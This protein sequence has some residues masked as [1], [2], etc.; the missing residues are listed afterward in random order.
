M[1]V[2]SEISV[3]YVEP[4][5]WRCGP[6]QVLQNLVH[7]LDHDVIRPHAVVPRHGDASEDFS[8]LGVPVHRLRA[9]NNL[10]RKGGPAGLVAGTLKASLGALQVAQFA[11]SHSVGVVHTNNETCLS[12]G[13]GARLARLPSI[14]HVHGLGFASSR[15]MGSVVARILNATADRVIAVSQVVSIALEERGVRPEKIRVVH[16]GIDTDRYRPGI[17]SNK[18]R[19][20][21]QLSAD[22]RTVGMIGALEPRKG[23]E[24]FVRSAAEVRRSQPGARFFIMGGSVPT[25]SLAE[26]KGYRQRLERLVE[27]LGLGDSV[28]FTGEREDIPELLSML[29]VVVQPSTTEAGP[30][31]PLEAMSSG[32]P[33]VVTDVGANPEEVLDQ[34]TGIVVPPAD[35]QSM[36]E[37]IV[38]LLGD[39]E[40][41][42]RLGQA[43]RQRVEAQFSREAMASKIEAIY[44]DVCGLQ[45]T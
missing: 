37:A 21:F 14:V 31:V 23:H 8:E 9:I 39:A 34:Q 41:R 6:Q 43:G 12:G 16:N 24:L 29:D 10:G 4:F 35:P 15:L 30:L 5:Y 27:S 11:K 25:D 36:A 42:R 44:R 28:V 45:H 1:S 13:F 18:L 22:D 7:G 33:V 3:L 2:A 19:Q 20:E 17:D 38:A 40:L 26:S 32:K